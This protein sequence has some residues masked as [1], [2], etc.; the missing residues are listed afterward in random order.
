V[1]VWAV[2][3]EA[4][5]L[6]SLADYLGGFAADYL[7]TANI[8][9]RFKIPVSLPNVTLD[10]RTRHDLFLAVKEAL[11]NIVRH[12]SATEAEFHLRAGEQTL[13]IEIRD[14]GC[15]FDT[16]DFTVGGHGLKNIPERLAKI[17]GTC[18]LESRAGQGTIV[19]IRLPLSRLKTESPLPVPSDI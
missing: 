13:E 3:P 19:G 15:G 11:H 7:A 10:G 1:I 8:A 17:G 12:S 14:N 16:N 2:D 9:C 18:Q 4:N 5:S 6:Q